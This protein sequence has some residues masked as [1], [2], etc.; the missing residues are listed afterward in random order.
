EPAE[1]VHESAENAHDLP[2]N[3]QDNGAAAD[4]VTVDQVTVEDLVEA[5][6]APVLGAE[7]GDVYLP[8]PSA[9]HADGWVEGVIE[10]TEE[11]SSEEPAL[12]EPAPQRSPG[13]EALDLSHAFQRLQHAVCAHAY[14]LLDPGPE[15]AEIDRCRA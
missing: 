9:A 4:P 10:E 2:V 7:G 3:G 13:I 8:R 11:E 6:H 5:G 15:Q 12:E 14:A 1:N